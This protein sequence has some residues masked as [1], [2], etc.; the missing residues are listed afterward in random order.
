MLLLLFTSSP[1]VLVGFKVAQ[2]G[3]V[4]NN[5][6]HY[7]TATASTGFIFTATTLFSQPMF[8]CSLVLGGHRHEPTE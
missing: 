4:P 8:L 5:F 3:A 2:I 7:T 6:A 1:I